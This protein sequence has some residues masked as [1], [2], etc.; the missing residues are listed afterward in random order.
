MI[1]VK[2]KVKINSEGIEVFF[3]FLVGGEWALG[4][5]I[6]FCESLTFEVFKYKCQDSDVSLK[7]IK[8]FSSK[9]INLG[10]IKPIYI[11]LN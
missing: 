10:N 1:F 9:I 11:Y 8:V 4:L 5:E 6:I 7:V 3:F 2:N